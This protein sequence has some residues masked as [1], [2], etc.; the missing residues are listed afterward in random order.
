MLKKKWF[1]TCKKIRTLKNWSTIMPLTRGI[2]GYGTDPRVVH[3]PS[4]TRWSDHSLG[5]GNRRGWPWLWD[6]LR[7]GGTPC[8]GLRMQE[9]ITTL[10][11][12][13]GGNEKRGEV[14]DS[15]HIKVWVA[16]SRHSGW[17][18]I[19]NFPLPLIWARLGQEGHRA[20]AKE[21]RL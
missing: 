4:K 13:L 8:T 16:A 15:S 6:G 17:E 11:G 7:E 9:C 5:E 14:P 20:T 21:F 19:W 2:G 18:G 12:F 1:L 3:L 10:P